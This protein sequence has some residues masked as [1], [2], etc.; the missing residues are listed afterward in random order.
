MER[1]NYDVKPLI[2]ARAAEIPDDAAL[3]IVAGPR[4]ELLVPELA[5]L[6]NYVKKGG[7]LF[8]MADP[9][10]LAASPEGAVADAIQL[11]RLAAGP[12]DAGVR[13]VG[14]AL[15]VVEP[16]DQHARAAGGGEVLELVHQSRACPT[17]PLMVS[18]P[19]TTS[20]WPVM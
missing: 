16:V 5:A 9:V 8:V 15:R 3:V 1:A 12:D 7:K 4:T 19:S 14:D 20:S 2:T 11:A 18:P 10:I 17:L 13:V 6:D